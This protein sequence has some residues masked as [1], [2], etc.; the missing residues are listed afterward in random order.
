MTN[1]K[2]KFHETL[3]NPCRFCGISKVATAQPSPKSHPAG[4]LFL[5][6]SCPASENFLETHR[7]RHGRIV[8]AGTLQNPC[9]PVRG[10][11]VK[12]PSTVLNIGDELRRP[13]WA[14]LEVRPGANCSH[15]RGE[16][17]CFWT[18]FSRSDPSKPGIS[19][20]QKNTPGRNGRS[21]Q[22][23]CV[24]CASPVLVFGPWHFLYFI[25]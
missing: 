22:C 1:P 25:M 12:R 11:S 6:K 10:P 3:H 23:A 13:P 9:H 14:L 15:T 16:N 19:P 8:I 18:T 21:F 17:E 20:S 5:Q 4:Q 7:H 24:F 2:S